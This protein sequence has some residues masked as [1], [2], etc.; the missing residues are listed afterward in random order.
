MSEL[1]Q[2]N[3]VVTFDSDKLDVQLPVGCPLRGGACLLPPLSI[4]SFLCCKTSPRPGLTGCMA[5]HQKTTSPSSLWLCVVTWPSPINE[6]RAETI[7]TA[8]LLDD[9]LKGNER[10]GLIALIFIPSIRTKM[11]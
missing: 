10:E 2:S 6:T 1:G 9:M 11:R 8:S 4:L 5:D 7:W 3:I